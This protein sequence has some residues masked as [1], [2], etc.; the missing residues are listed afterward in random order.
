M[1]RA[2]CIGAGFGATTLTAI[3]I[4]A[5]SSSA[6]N[7]DKS[8]GT[9]L[10]LFRGVQTFGSGLPFNISHGWLTLPRATEALGKWRFSL[11]V[12]GVEVK[13]DF[14]ETTRSDDPLLGTLL[15]RA[16][17]FNFR[18]GMTGTHVFE[19]TFL[20]PC[21]GLVDSGFAT[22]PCADANAEIPTSA[23]PFITTVTFV[24]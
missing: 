10:N 21:Q 8:V 19:G 4:L 7:P 18:D 5:P 9:P 15:F 20:G 12:D 22:G 11:T 3:L 17:V 2:L 6:A 16:Y 1:K 13:P 23:S 14:I 24:P